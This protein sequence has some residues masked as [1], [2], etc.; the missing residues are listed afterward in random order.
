MFI[1]QNFPGMPIEIL[2]NLTGRFYTLVASIGQ[3]TLPFYIVYGITHL[4]NIKV[5]KLEEAKVY[6]N[7]H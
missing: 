1:S 6:E 5:K 2:Y 3:M 4:K 7:V